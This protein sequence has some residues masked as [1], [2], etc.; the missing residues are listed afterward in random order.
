MWNVIGRSIGVMRPRRAAA[1]TCVA[2]GLGVLAGVPAVAADRH[3]SLGFE[4]YIGGFSALSLGVEAGLKPRA[5]TVDFRFGTRGV[6]SW[7][8]DWT[9]KSYSRGVF[10]EGRMVPASAGA[11]SSWN[12]RQR[13]TRLFYGNDGS[14]SAHL[15]PPAREDDE[16]TPVPEHVKRGAVDLSTALFAT[17]DAVERDGSCKQRA[18]V[19]D[20]RRRYDLV[21]ED[22]GKGAIAAGAPAIYH[23]PTLLCRLGIEPVAGFRPAGSRLDWATGDEALIHVAQVFDGAPPVPVAIEYETRL[24]LLRA[25][26]TDALF[27][28]GGEQQRLATNPSDGRSKSGTD[29]ASR[30]AK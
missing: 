5:Y 12:G 21:F 28:N 16:R 29:R 19:F 9:M 30:P 27:S 15:V 6:A 22:G 18:K 3:L 26:L 8:V 11:D 24:G 7:L 14:V 17:L 10:R 1:V 25:Y 20:G 13:I 4:A 2:A 23:G